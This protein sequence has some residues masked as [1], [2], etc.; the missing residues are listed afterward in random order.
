MRVHSDSTTNIVRA[1]QV[2][3]GKTKKDQ[4]MSNELTKGTVVRVLLN[5]GATLGTGADMIGTHGNMWIVDAQT[6]SDPDWYWCRSATT[7]H[8]FDWHVS[9]MEVQ[10]MEHAA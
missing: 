7:N 2:A 1:T 8:L 6:R 9:E 3:V 10:V 4:N 5:R